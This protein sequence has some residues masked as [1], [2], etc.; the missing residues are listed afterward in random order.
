MLRTRVLFGLTA[1]AIGL[2]GC[3]GSVGDDGLDVAAAATGNG[4]PNGPHFTLNVIG[5][6]S[7]KS[8]TSGGG[9]ALFVPLNGTAKINL[10]EGDFA[11]LD[12]N[13][14]DG[15]CQF[16]L[17]NPDPDGDGTTTY[18]VFARALGKP[19]GSATSTTCASDATT[20]ETFCSVFSSVQ[21][22]TKG[23]QTF[24]NVSRELLFVFADVDGDGV[25]ERHA[26]FDDALQNFFWQFDNNGLKLLQYRFVEVP[27]TVQ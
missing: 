17:P 5:V 22:R 3:A 11:V 16:Q 20:G 10:S 18:S 1:A 19:G 12:K 2:A 4:S 6:S 21:T 25:V 24:T 9:S 8:I 14:T 23:K 13:C 7:A 15:S 27:T 26:L